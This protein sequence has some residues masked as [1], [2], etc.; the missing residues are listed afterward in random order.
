[1]EKDPNWKPSP[2]IVPWGLRKLL[3]WVK[4]EYDNPLV[5]ITETGYPDGGNMNDVDRA[6]YIKVHF[7]H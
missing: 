3:N 4:K 6:T 1:M 2:T 5:Y 7:Q